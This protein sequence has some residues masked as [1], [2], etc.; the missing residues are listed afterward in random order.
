MHN[1]FKIRKEFKKKLLNRSRLFGGWLSYSN[2]AI[3]ET[4]A[5]ADF[6]FLAIDME[7]STISLEQAQRIIA[8][9]QGYSVPCLPRPVSHSNDWLKPILDSG[10][11]GLFIPMVNT[12]EEVKSIIN[13]FK[14]PP[15]G[16]RSYGLNR[17][18]A[19]GFDFDEYVECWNETS[20]LIIQIESIDAVS[21][22]DN[23]ISFDEVDG[24]M[25]GPYDLSG[26]L[27]LPGQTEHP[28]VIEA[29]LKVIEACK[30]YN[31]SCGTQLSDPNKINIKEVFD[32]GHNFVILSSDLFILWK[33]AEEMKNLIINFKK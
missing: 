17:A 2:S 20:S 12:P 30:K 4:F 8:S 22:I 25:I 21:N 24:V 33:W 28:K 19:Y 14:Y 11:D 23:L 7:H 5:K 16:K 13:D 3:A 31:K 6:D 15:K 1:L 32:L 29:S 27:N 18:Q 10:A 26:S 9:S